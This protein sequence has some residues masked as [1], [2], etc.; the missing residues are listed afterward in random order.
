MYAQHKRPWPQI[1]LA[2]LRYCLA[3]GSSVEDMADFLHRDV[4]DVRY[5]IAIEAQRAGSL[6][7]LVGIAVGDERTPLVPPQRSVIL[8]AELREHA[9]GEP[10]RVRPGQAR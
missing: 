3:F 9:R 10:I 7:S 5:K 8:D 2:E 1:D 4:E 6:R